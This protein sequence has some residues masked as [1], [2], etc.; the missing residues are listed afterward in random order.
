MMLLAVDTSGK[1][2]SL[3]LA[4]VELGQER[5]ELLELA[6]LEGGAFSAQLVPE[7][8]ALLDRQGC[9][10]NDV[11]GFAVAAGPGSF[12]GLR[13]GLAAI[14][15]LGEALQKPIMA[16]SLLEAVAR[17]GR[18]AR[19]LAVLE[20]GRGDVYC[21]DYEVNPALRMRSERLLSREEMV[22]AA[23]GKAVVTPER[24]LAEELRSAGVAVMVAERPD[25]GVIARVGW[26]RWQRGET[27][28]PEELEANY[29]RRTDAEIFSK[30]AR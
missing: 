4:R 11:D 22:E 26:E 18:Q 17:S 16:V 24:E 2:G 8:A 23:R 25:A 15:A 3:A 30:R 9:T 19:V 1:E 28:G 6:R 10:R 27:V 14:K 13:V 20:A 21:G 7:M 12:T 29:I 5:I